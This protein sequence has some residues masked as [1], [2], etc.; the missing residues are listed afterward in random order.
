M[1]AKETS[2]NP[3]G[4]VYVCP[5]VLVSYVANLSMHLGTSVFFKCLH[6]SISF[7]HKRVFQAVF[8]VVLTRWRRLEWLA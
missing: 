4:W 8:A 2:E 3:K 7:K 1:R 6:S 5:P